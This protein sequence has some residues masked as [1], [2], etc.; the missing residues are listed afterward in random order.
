MATTNLFSA[1]LTNHVV[2]G[3]NWHSAILA[4]E[5][6]LTSFQKRSDR[7]GP[8]ADLATPTGQPGLPNRSDRFSSN[9][10]RIEESLE[11]TICKRISLRSKTPNP[12]NIKGHGQLRVNPI[13]QSNIP[14]LFISLKP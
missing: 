7:F 2:G 12:I 13:D 6:S 8:V 10:T 9:P 11:I 1:K 14:L 3:Q 5:T 4:G